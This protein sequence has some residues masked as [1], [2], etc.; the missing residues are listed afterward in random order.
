[1]E[2]MKHR[3]APATL[4]LNLEFRHQNKANMLTVSSSFPSKIVIGMLQLYLEQQQDTK[5]EIQKAFFFFII[6]S[7]V[8]S[9]L[10]TEILYENY[11]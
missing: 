11:I 2:V 8:H 7:Y 4:G 6:K 3:K 1:M 5:G 10:D 9:P